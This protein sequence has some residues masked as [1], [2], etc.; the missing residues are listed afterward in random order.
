MSNNFNQS[1]KTMLKKDVIQYFGTASNTARAF[2]VTRQA[3]DR[4]PEVL[5]HR[6]LSKCIF[7]LDKEAIKEKNSKEKARAFMYKKYNSLTGEVTYHLTFSSNVAI[8][9]DLFAIPLYEKVGDK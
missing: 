3:V 9:N 6:I 2:E 8:K 1:G 7:P 5:T 4:W